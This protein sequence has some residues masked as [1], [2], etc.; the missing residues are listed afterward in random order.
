MN[1]EAR[2]AE[3][4]AVFDTLA[5]TY[6]TTLAGPDTLLGLLR[7]QNLTRLEQLFPPGAWVLELGCGTGEEALHLAARGCQVWG[8]DLSPR[9]IARAQEKARAR[10]LEGR[11][12]FRVLE[13]GAVAALS[14]EIPAERLTG[15]FA[16]LGVIN[17]EPQLE[18]LREGL[19]GLLKPSGRF[20]VQGM[21]NRSLFERLYG[22]K[23]LNPGLERQRL[24]PGNGVVGFASQTAEGLTTP[25]LPPQTLADRFKPYFSVDKAI[26]LNPLLPSLALRETFARHQKLY[27]RLAELQRW[28]EGDPWW[29]RETDLYGLLLVRETLELGGRPHGPHWLAN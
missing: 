20:F 29:V 13:A 4:R 28:V 2:Y 16:G 12:H 24:Q 9:M 27:Q 3:L 22:F 11:A 15:A 23:H 8:I 7:M 6:D 25:F 1:P 19:A 21:N 10:H 26:A 5:D 17:H 18:S 14:D